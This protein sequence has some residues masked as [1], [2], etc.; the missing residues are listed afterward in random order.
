M[1][2]QANKVRMDWWHSLMYST[3]ILLI[4]CG[5]PGTILVAFVLMGDRA[6]HLDRSEALLFGGCMIAAEVIIAGIFL[7]VTE[8]ITKRRHPNTKNDDA[9]V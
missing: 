7:Y 4:V 2:R 6:V 3:G 8:R 9:D 1:E 5:I